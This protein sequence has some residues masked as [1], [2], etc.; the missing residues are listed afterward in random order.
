MLG[1]RR[2]GAVVATLFFLGSFQPELAQS[3]NEGLRAGANRQ[4]VGTAAPD[5]DTVKSLVESSKGALE[6]GELKAAFDHLKTLAAMANAPKQE[7]TGLLTAFRQSLVRDLPF[8]KAYSVDAKGPPRSICV[9]RGGEAVAWASSQSIFVWRPNQDQPR[10]LQPVWKS[11]VTIYRRGQPPIGPKEVKIVPDA[12]VMLPA[13]NAM[14]VAMSDQ[15]YVVSASAGEL[16]QTISRTTGWEFQGG[17]AARI[18][19][20][21]ISNLNSAWMSLTPEGNFLVWGTC[22]TPNGGRGRSGRPGFPAIVTQIASGQ[23]L[24]VESG[25]EPVMAASVCPRTGR[26]A[27]LRSSGM[28]TLGRFVLDPSKCPGGG[29]GQVKQMGINVQGEVWALGATGR[30]GIWSAEN[31]QF[32]R[33]IDTGKG[34]IISTSADCGDNLVIVRRDG[35]AGGVR[36]WNMVNGKSQAVTAG[37]GVQAAVLSGDGTALVTATLASGKTTVA[38]WGRV[39]DQP[40]M[41]E[42]L[43]LYSKGTATDVPPAGVSN[44]DKHWTSEMDTLAQRRA[45]NRTAMSASDYNRMY[46]TTGDNRINRGAPSAGGSGP[47]ARTC[48]VC[49]GSGVERV[50]NAADGTIFS[51][52]TVGQPTGNYRCSVCGGTGKIA[53]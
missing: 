18:P 32:A 41:S 21:G 11:N 52:M 2:T 15:F 27:A 33:V 34:A 13:G 39:T 31:G 44:A 45:Q 14:V 46:N 30:V 16:V 1:L 19:L 23:N 28:I 35:E 5:G 50:V 12:M 43:A 10:E 53:E 26:V 48:R 22:Q 3:Q 24:A 9:S 51:K 8:Q 49:N 6:R 38:W 42:A 36:V 47:S 37:N 40:W 25:V 7:V 20:K 29:I 4:A 17:D